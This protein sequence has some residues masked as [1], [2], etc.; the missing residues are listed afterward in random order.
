MR[1]ADLAVL[2]A[3]A[4]VIGVT[5][6]IV[7]RA[8]GILERWAEA[9]G[10]RI[11]SSQ[12]RWIRRGPFFFRTSRAQIVFRIEVI[13]PDGR[14]RAGWARVGGALSGVLSDDVSVMWDGA[15]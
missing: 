2:L 9:A 13:E 8:R 4:V 12:V 5:V 11:E 14:M 7:S 1:L 10:L 3:F 6:M 15:E